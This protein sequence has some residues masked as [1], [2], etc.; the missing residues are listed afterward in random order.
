LVEDALNR[1]TARIVLLTVS[2]T[3]FVVL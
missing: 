1:A 2:T 3:A